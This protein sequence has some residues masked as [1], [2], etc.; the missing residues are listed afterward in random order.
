MKRRESGYPTSVGT[1]LNSIF[2]RSGLTASLSRYAILHS[3][4]RIV[5]WQVA[6]H[7]KAEK[8]TG[9]TLH[10]AVDSAAWMNELAAIKNLLL[11]KLNAHIRPGA[12][13][14]ADIRFSQRS[15]AK[16]TK[17]EPA[18]PKPPHAT[19]QE[20]EAVDQMLEA[21]KDD[22]LRQML[23]R[24]MEKDRQLKWRRI[25]EEERSRS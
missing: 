1:V 3:W 16:A 12:A 13:P 15:W 25:H 10:V 4:P 19:E 18:P 2:A 24:I 7:A 23:K 9:A 20:R 5:G 22:K 21:V 14:L 17:P 8:V 6:R 11:E